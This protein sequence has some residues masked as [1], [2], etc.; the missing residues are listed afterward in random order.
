MPSPVRWRSSIT[1]LAEISAMSMLRLARV[2]LVWLVSFAW[3][4]ELRRRQGVPLKPRCVRRTGRA[5]KL[6]TPPDAVC[7][8]R[9]PALTPDGKK[10]PEGP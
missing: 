2:S 8:W 9:C 6:L 10:G 3:L 1:L 7:G 5:G 4:S